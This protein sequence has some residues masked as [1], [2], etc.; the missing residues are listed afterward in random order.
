MAVWPE[1]MVPQGRAW[2]GSWSVCDPSQ[3]ISQHKESKGSKGGS[4]RTQDVVS[5]K[6]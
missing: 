3:D 2:E 1:A 4:R 6:I 5:V